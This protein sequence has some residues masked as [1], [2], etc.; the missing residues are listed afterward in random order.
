[1][2]GAACEPLGWKKP[3]NQTNQ[4]AAVDS[5]AGFALGDLDV[6]DDFFD[7]LSSPPQTPISSADSRD[8]EC[9]PD[10]PGRSTGDTGGTVKT[11]RTKFCHPMVF[12][13]QDKTS[14]GSDPCDFCSSAYF[15]LIGLEERTTEVIEWYDGRGWEE[16]GG[17][18]KGD[19]IK[20]SKMCTDCTMARMQIMIC[21]DHALRRTTELGAELDHE[22][23]FERLFDPGMAQRDQWCLVCCNLAAWECC[24]GQETQPGEGC[25]LALCEACFTDLE[26][27]GGSLETMLQILEDEPGEARP[28]GLR[29]D[30]ELLKEDGL[31]MRYLKHAAES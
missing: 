7:I 30:Y 31:L 24:L 4:Q 21:D 1:M 23:A 27:C 14:N 12:D 6:D 18:H 20:G 25:G 29:A 9:T 5:S 16:I 10:P 13:Y 22:A 15:S 19:S 26:I 11:V 8:S 17:G 3:E 2:F 28:T